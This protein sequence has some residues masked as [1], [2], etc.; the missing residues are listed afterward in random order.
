MTT[1]SNDVTLVPWK[2]VCE[3]CV[4]ESELAPSGDTGRLPGC[5]LCGATL[6][7][8]TLV[9]TLIAA[10]SESGDLRAAKFAD[11][12][13][14]RGL[15]FGSI[16]VAF[17]QAKYT[18]AL[19]DYPFRGDLRDLF[20][21]QHKSAP[22]LRIPLMDNLLDAL[23]VE[24]SLAPDAV[25]E[26]ARRVLRPGGVLA[27]PVCDDNGMPDAARVLQAHRL[28]TTGFFTHF[29]QPGVAFGQAGRGA[30]LMAIAPGTAS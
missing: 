16:G 28:Q 4:K 5:P 12:K 23:I 9:V 10:F 18:S 1:S 27:M 13:H 7:D 30:L 11:E 24:A 17:S 15:K 21:R 3:F 8:R 25:L 2:T 20:W 22:S 19:V 14:T 26:E 6:Q 29:V